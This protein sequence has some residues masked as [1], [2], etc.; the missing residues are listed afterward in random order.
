MKTM[1]R[2]L[3]K[4]SIIRNMLFSYL[5]INLLLLFLLGIVSI[6][7]STDTMTKE[8][9]KSSYKLMEQAARGFN[10]SL[11]EA[12][13]PL[14]QFAGNYSVIALMTPDNK[15][16]VEE[17]IQHERNIGELAAGV[18]AF[19]S[20]ISDVL[21]LGYNGYLNNL[22]GRKTLQWDFPFVE[23]PWFKT[24]VSVSPNKGFITLN[25]H[26]QNYYVSN[27]VSKY[28]QFTFSIALPVKD[29]NQ[30]T[31]GA[32][33][34]N[35]D[36]S[37]INGLFELT[38]DQNDES[39]F[40]IDEDRTVVVHQDKNSIGN[41]MSFVGIDTLFERDSGSFVTTI[42]GKDRLVIFH[43][44]AV[45][46]L[47]LVSTIPMSEIRGQSDS[48]R[49]NL[50]NILYLCL[51]ANTL[52]SIIITL[53]FS[54]P[55][56]RLLA[57]LDN[58]G[59]KSLYVVPK[60]YKYRELNL[61][62]DKFKEL[63]GRIEQLVKQNYVSQIALQDAQLKTLQSQIHPHFLFNTLQLVQTEIV[64]G[65]TDESNHLLLSLSSLLRYSMKGSK[66]M[67]EIGR[68][69]QNVKDYLFIVNKKFAGRI[70]I[71]Y[72]VPDPD[73]LGFK[74]IKLI[75]QPIV[76]NAIVHGF[77]ENPKFARI[78]IHLQNVK[79]GILISIIDNGV[80]M[81]KERRQWLVSQMGSADIPLENIGLGN[82][83]QRIKLRFGPDYGIRIRSHEG[84]GTRIYLL[85]PRQ[86]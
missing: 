83:D 5:G 54:R 74:T 84:S 32:V 10:F 48:L 42:E 76:E 86:S 49:T 25:L 72:V 66:E 62:G 34:A 31:I 67:V 11:E 13:R 70:D 79:R 58:M 23:Q 85:L 30:H 52:L 14:V 55:F 7:D 53:R 8:I 73:V 56:S 12:K 63:V 69:L 6:R 65:N 9:T 40:M 50:A 17:R 51:M 26:K 47:R 16:S 2:Q 59:D 20:M 27:N 80:G 46:E 81:S 60:N 75:L 19:Q 57:T 37:K 68:E 4:R 77:E 1:F 38:S 15:V 45:K 82:V 33:V 71:D 3:W 24:A 39:I 78:R 21:I 64:C 44:T 28:N 29:F 43:P 35:L 61:I 36:L 41:V 18:T 22:D